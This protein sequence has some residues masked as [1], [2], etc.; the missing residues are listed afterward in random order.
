VLETCHDGFEIAERDLS[1]RGAG[2]VFGSG[3]K[4][5]GGRRRGFA[6]IALMADPFVHK[7]SVV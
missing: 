1:L 3:T 6:P 5:S 7:M 2:Q 4:Q